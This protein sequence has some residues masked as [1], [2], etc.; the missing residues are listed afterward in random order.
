MHD[1]YEEETDH[2]KD[3]PVL[4]VSPTNK[5]TICISYDGVYKV[6]SSTIF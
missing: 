3:Q 5:M 2:G 6:I 1:Q 4:A